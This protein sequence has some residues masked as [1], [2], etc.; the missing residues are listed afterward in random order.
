M[1]ACPTG[2]LRYEALEGLKQEEPEDLTTVEARPNGPLFLRGRLQ[3]KG[4][5]GKA[6]ADEYRLA[7]CR[8]G[9]SENKLCC[10]AS[11]RLIGFR[12][13]ALA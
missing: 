2:A 6:M 9:G 12:D 1:R 5:G 8:C 3:V 4:P 10:D 11:H 13:S 7:L